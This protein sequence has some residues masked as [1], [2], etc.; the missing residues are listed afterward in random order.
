MSG[1]GFLDC[2]P[3]SKRRGRHVDVTDAVFGERVDDRVHHR[4]QRAGATGLAA[5]LSAER[6]GLGRHRVA[7]DLEPVEEADP[8]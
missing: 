2:L 1:A 7:V 6:I 4:R 8:E 5:A 3:Y